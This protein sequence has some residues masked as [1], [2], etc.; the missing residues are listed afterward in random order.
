MYA[1]KKLYRFLRRGRWRR[2][3]EDRPLPISGLSR[4]EM[5]ALF[6]SRP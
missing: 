4:L 2:L 6:M 5:V 1:L 3:Q